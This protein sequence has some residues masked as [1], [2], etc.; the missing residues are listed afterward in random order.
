MH[1]T[2]CP[3]NAAGGWSEEAEGSVSGGAERHHLG[4][5][6]GARAS[7]PAVPDHRT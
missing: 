1:Y 4:E 2:C 3:H 7:E 6:E 5:E